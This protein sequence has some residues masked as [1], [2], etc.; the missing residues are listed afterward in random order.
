M[1]FRSGKT[2]SEIH[3]AIK[4]GLAKYGLIGLR[5]DDK[6]YPT[7]GDLWSNICVYLMGCKYGVCVFEEI[8]EREFNPNVPLEYGFLRAINRQVLL[9]KD[10]RMPKLP[11]DMTGKIYRTFDSYS[12]TE[13]VHQQVSEWAERDLGLYP[14][15][16]SPKV[17]EL[18]D[19]LSA[20]SVLLM[21][22]FTPEQ[23]TI[24]GNLRDVL[25]ATGH[26]ALFFDI[27]TIPKEEQAD[28]MSAIVSLTPYILDVTEPTSA[29]ETELSALVP[30]VRSDTP[31]LKILK[32][33][34]V[35]SVDFSPEL[36]ASLREDPNRLQTLTPE[37]FERFV[38]E[39]LDCMGYNVTLTGSTNRKDGGI[40]LIAVPKTSNL[41]SIV[42]A[43]QVKHHRD[44]RKTG[45]EAVD[46]L[47]A[48][49]D[50]YF[51]VGLL[52]T[53]TAFTKDALWTAQQGRNRHFLRLR[54]FADLK[55]WLHDDFGKE[56][57]F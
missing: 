53:N 54:D 20:K 9:L 46:Q 21:G 10:Q 49:M 4:A 50:T 28:T 38:A 56:E 39:R 11:T 27:G 40:D 30:Q 44:D 48:W 35:R 43:G 33:N 45:R 36:L 32:S 31:P 15:T 37:Q 18:L 47:L 13:T 29:T 23:Q 7:D 52:V 42:I 6:A 8:D 14:M 22:R 1:R 5:A 41:G 34:I 57:V 16:Q 26:E 17:S 2:F 3:Q 19:R 24:L 51:G 25:K 12:I 55:R